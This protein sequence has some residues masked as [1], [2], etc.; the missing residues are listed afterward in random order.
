MIKNNILKVKE[1]IAGACLRVNRRPGDIKLVCVTKGR[2]AEAIRQVLASGVSDMGENKVQE[3]LL[4]YNDGQLSGGN[5]ITWH[6]IGHLQANKVKSAVKIFDLI[7]SVD[8]L[9][10]AQEI[11]RQA[12]KINKA[13]DILLEVKTSSELTKSGFAPGQLPEAKIA[14]SNLA[15]IRVLGLMTIPAL[16][17]Q[18]QEARKYFQ[19][20]RQLRDSLEPRWRLS[21]G[22]SGDFEAAIEEGADIIRV[23]RAIFEG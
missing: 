22:M 10:L 21:M 2:D 3:A 4:K 14:L 12:A 23:G 19:V 15:N 6:M 5:K 20:L 16:A 7:H 17:D 18:A 9:A 11:N 13:Q 1:K 8:S